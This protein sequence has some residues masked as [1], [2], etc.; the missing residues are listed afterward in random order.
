M[1]MQFFSLPIAAGLFFLTAS[2]SGALSASQVAE[3]AKAVTVS[4]QTPDSIGSGVIIAKTPVSYTVLTAAHVVR[5]PAATYQ[6][7]TPDGLRYDLNRQTIKVLPNADLALVQFNTAKNY[8]VVKIRTATA[9]PEGSNVYVG[10]FPLSTK[11][12]SQ[13]LFNF[14]EGRVTASS[15]KPLQD[16]YGLVYTNPTLP[17][18]SGG[19][20]L[21]EQGEL[22]AIHGRGDV[23]KG[24][25]SST[26]NPSIRVKTGFNLGILANVFLPLINQTGLKIEANS[27]TTN[28]ATANDD[29]LVSAAIKIQSGDYSGALAD[30]NRSITANPRRASAY[31]MRANINQSIGNRSQIIPDLNKAIELDPRNPQAYYLRGSMLQ[32]NDD[33][34]GALADFDRVI[35][36]DAKNTYAHLM[37]AIIFQRQGDLPGALLAYTKLIAADPTYSLA[38]ENRAGIKVQLNDFPGAIADFTQAIAIN[39]KNINAYENRAHFRKYSGDVTGALADYTKIIELSPN[40]MR[41]YS[42]RAELYKQRKDYAK[43]LADY[44]RVLKINPNEYQAYSSQLEI[45]RELKDYSGIVKSLTGLTRIYPNQ[46]YYWK[47]L[48]DAQVVVRNKSAAILSYQKALEIYRQQGNTS[49]AEEMNKKIK[50]LNTRTI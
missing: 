17:G 22:I 38:Y 7:V 19:S 46:V 40:N 43:A 34:S 3:V 23:E 47:D 10:G 45:H 9:I 1:N 28:L 31:Y 24:T 29:S 48:G 2:S 35:Q 4:I 26:I 25:E 21:N 27:S 30:L 44:D 42:Y 13:S 41:G 36:L 5:D 39:P 16:G 32:A 15:S 50:E 20:V 37:R 8:R 11:A 49:E 6:L 33:L 12:I 14:T 18:M